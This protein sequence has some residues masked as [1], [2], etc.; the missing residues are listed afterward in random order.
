M[1]EFSD[2]T[3]FAL[4]LQRKDTR[5]KLTSRISA[6]QDIRRRIGPA[7][8]CDQVADWL[9]AE[10]EALRGLADSLSG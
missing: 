1:S 3:K 4:K 9:D 8:S 2:E 10:I 5:I 6:I 7:C